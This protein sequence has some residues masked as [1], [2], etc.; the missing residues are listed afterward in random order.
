MTLEQIKTMLAD[1][2][3]RAVSK[4]A[5]VHPNA[6]YRLM[7]GSTNPRYDTVQKLI[8]YLQGRTEVQN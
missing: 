4:A 3:I 7:N 5:G 8:A 2:N 1:R 6:V